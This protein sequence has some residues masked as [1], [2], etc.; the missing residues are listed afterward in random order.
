MARPLDDQALPV[1][2]TSQKSCSLSQAH[3]HCIHPQPEESFILCCWRPRNHHVFSKSEITSSYYVGYDSVFRRSEMS[4]TSNTQF[5]RYAPCDAEG[6]LTD[7]CREQG[8][9]RMSSVW[10]CLSPCQ[11]LMYLAPLHNG[12]IVFPCLFTTSVA[13]IRA[14]PPLLCLHS[15]ASKAKWNS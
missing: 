14:C 7:H 15:I 5:L 3:T 10:S 11:Q 4:R 2:G 12:A 9:I 1:S 8:D 13:S 6:Q